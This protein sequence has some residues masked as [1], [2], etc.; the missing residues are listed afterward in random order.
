MSSNYEEIRK[1]N[2]RKYG[3]ET[4]H[5][6]YLSDLYPIRT[7]FL[8]ELL[9]NA[10]DALGKRQAPCTDRVVEFRLFPDRL[11]FRHNGKPFDEGDVK[12][13]CGIKKGT[14]ASDHSQIGKFGIGFKSVYAYTL[15][16]HV[17]CDD[18]HFE[19]QRFV[20]PH[21]LA[22]QANP[23]NVRPEETCIVLPFDKPG[24][25][26]Q[27]R[28]HIPPDRAATEILKGLK[29]LGPRSLLFLKHTKEI[30][31]SQHD[32]ESGHFRRETRPVLDRPV[33]RYVD[34]KDGEITETWIIFERP[35][36]IRDEDDV[37][38]ESMPEA[39]LDSI[40]VEVAFLIENEKV[41]PA[42]NTELVVAFPTEKKT[43]LGF[44]IQGPFKTTK[45]RD[46][47]ERDSDAN[48]QMIEAA[49]KL[50]AD[51]L[52][53]L[54]DLG[55]LSL[56]SYN[57]LPLKASTFDDDGTRFFKPVYDAVR[58]GLRTKPLLPRRGGRF[59][60]AEQ[61]RLAG[62]A[63][64]A[65]VFSPRQLGRLFGSVPLYWL[66]TNIT[67]GGKSDLYPFLKG[68]GSRDW[69]QEPLVEGIEID[70]PQVAKRLS[71]AF[72]ARQG[73]RWLKCF[74][75][76]IASN[77]NA[78][79][80]TP[81]LRLANGTHVTP[82][83]EDKPNAYLPAEGA[84]DSTSAE[85]AQVLPSLA[86]NSSVDRFLRKTVGLREP[87]R[88]DVV[89]RSILPKYRQSSINVD[90]ESAEYEDDLR[91]IAAVCVE[92]GV[93]PADRSR[94][95]SELKE[96]R[97][98]ACKSASG[99]VVVPVWRT[100]FD[101]KLLRGSTE[102]HEWFRENTDDSFWLPTDAAAAHLGVVLRQCPDAVASL[103]RANTARR[104]DAARGKHV[105]PT[106][107]FDPDAY[108]AG[109]DFAVRN[110]TLERA[111]YLWQTL[112]VH[113]TLIRGKWFQST[114]QDFPL[115]YRTK[116]K[117]DTS[118]LGHAVMNHEWLPKED[119]LGFFPP[120]ALYLEDLPRDGFEKDSQRAVALSRALGMK[121]AVDLGPVSALL[122]LTQ[123]QL[124]ARRS[125]KDEEV[126]EIYRQRQARQAF[127]EIEPH[128]S[129]RR[130]NRIKEEARKAPRRTSS[131][132][133]VTATDD[134]E[135]D[136]KIAKQYLREQY[137]S[138]EVV[139]CQ[140]S[141]EPM[142]FKVRDQDEW[143]FEAVE[144]VPGTRKFYRENYLALSPHYA[145]MFQYANHDRER[146]RDL[147]LSAT[148]RDVPVRLYD[149]TYMLR[150]TSQHIADLKAVLEVDAELEE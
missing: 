40:V 51:S 37:D 25:P 71:A 29:A 16:P 2:I 11:E 76:Y 118:P 107:G 31:W 83:S 43:E 97:L 101:S 96:T 49:A 8:Y 70:P 42:R 44:L 148:G 9:Q 115:D 79:K 27:F 123:E 73:Q 128:A 81:F 143:Y 13:V 45:A 7:H 72:F 58:E 99:I 68:K 26:N 69:M 60:A 54:R 15:A 80:G 90:S 23:S 133:E 74:Y 141:H 146:M 132:K 36:S 24:S 34:V 4:D 103:L 149:S 122:G 138:G 113:Q 98:I 55:L 5:L 108:L 57:A 21:A 130:R 53:D 78:F 12:G 120:S 121:Q 89:I 116:E 136:K 3:E 150:F 20:E 30:R 77:Y 139:F 32:G 17:H 46:N 52:E 38:D 75:N 91:R 147:V 126:E 41:V 6:A 39:R 19:I 56:E 140:L 82:G 59:I 47:I 93:E 106:G 85:F 109:L 28:K 61:A 135:A 144:C 33:V 105:K 1:Q 64:L 87:N 66:D 100:P 35:C 88:V 119:D 22:P 131:I 127:P 137:R 65:E 142:P 117:E 124:E 95:L 129:Q 134:Y 62:V 50:A 94:L 14:K 84:G 92:E 114:R 112:L 63:Q 111:A 48:R 110:P 67:A 18:E 145:A 86:D 10:E 125:L 104:W 102:L